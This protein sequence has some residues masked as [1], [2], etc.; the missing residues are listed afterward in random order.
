MIHDLTYRV[1]ALICVALT[2]ASLLSAQTSSPPGGSR[3]DDPITYPIESGSPYT[4]LGFGYAFAPT[5]NR[6]VAGQIVVDSR[7]SEEK[8]R[9]KVVSSLTEIRQTYGLSSEVSG[10]YGPF[11]GSASHQTYSDAEGKRSFNLLSVESRVHRYSRRLTDPQLTPPAARALERSATSF[12]QMCGTAF[13]AGLDYGGR[14][15]AYALFEY[16][17]TADRDSSRTGFEGRLPQVA[18]AEA[19]FNRMVSSVRRSTRRDMGYLVL[20]DV[21]GPRANT[22]SSYEAYALQFR[23]LVINTPGIYQAQTVAFTPNML[24]YCQDVNACE[25]NLRQVSS[26]R[27]AIDLLLQQSEVARAHLEEYRSIFSSSSRDLYPQVDWD[28]LRRDSTRM[29]GV[30]EQLR[31]SAACL[32]SQRTCPNPV[33]TPISLPPARLSWNYV[34]VTQP[35]TCQN[36]SSQG[37]EPR[38]I[39]AR[40]QWRTFARLPWQ[41]ATYR[42]FVYFEYQNGTVRRVPYT[43]GEM[44][45]PPGPITEICFGVAPY[46][47]H[48]GNQSRQS[49]PLRFAVYSTRR[50]V[51]TPQLPAAITQH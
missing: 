26:G 4:D 14:F 30:A 11:L 31:A 3:T 47:T 46:I 29:R 35:F 49:D 37:G 34:D 48:I 27:G 39:A 28:V 25:R 8:Q 9:V 6:C 1:V 16:A 23:D 50:E 40:G 5:G 10:G 36:V 33:Q 45:L 24:R 43:G 18:G 17:T 41:P 32:L 7:S 22:P 2:P 12:Q 13:V 51:W 42:S 19:G 15:V 21:P 44:T 38:R 20:G